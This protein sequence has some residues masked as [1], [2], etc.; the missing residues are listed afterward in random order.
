MLSR[1]SRQMLSRSRT[2]GICCATSAMRFKPS[3]SATTSPLGGS[4]RR[5]PAEVAGGARTAG[6]PVTE[7]PDAATTPRGPAAHAG[8]R[9]RF[10]EAVRLHAAGVS[11]RQIARLL[12]TDCKTVRRWLRAGDIPSWRQPRRGRLLAAHRDHL[13]RRWGGGWRHA[14]PPWGGVAGGGLSGG[15]TP[16]QGPGAPPGQGWAPPG[17]PAP[18][19]KR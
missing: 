10:E 6:T 17:P 12:G 1:F 7:G 14:A 15:L 16:P 9:A 13:E 5:W 8:R 3:W 2:G 19:G 11:L 4:R 18:P